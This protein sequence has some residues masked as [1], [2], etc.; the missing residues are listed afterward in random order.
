LYAVW[1]YIVSISA[2]VI[3]KIC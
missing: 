2:I 3:S 1:L